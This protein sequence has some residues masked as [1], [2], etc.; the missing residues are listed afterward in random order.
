MASASNS[1]TPPDRH[2]QYSSLEDAL[3]LVNAHRRAWSPAAD[4]GPVALATPL[5]PGGTSNRSFLVHAGSATWV[6]R[7]DGIDPERNGIDRDTEFRLQA[8]AADAGLAPRPRFCDAAAGVLLVDYLAP[9]SGPAG[10]N[11]A[12]VARLLRAVHQLAVAAPR[13]YLEDRVAHYEA[14]VRTT[15]GKAVG[16]RLASLSPALRGACRRLDGDSEPAV[17]CHNDLT[18]ANR[19]SHRG[20]LY[21]L[22]WEYAA[23]GSRW[24]DLAVAAAGR[25]EARALLDAYLQRPATAPELAMFARARLVASYVELLWLACN[26]D[27]AM[28]R[29]SV[30]LRA[31]QARLDDTTGVDRPRAC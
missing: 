8:A 19:L 17:V 10:D 6:L 14:L 12:E 16:N 15:C 31:L 30:G 2:R 11:T 29:L 21:A 26:T 5:L 28:R 22:D 7:L 20:T 25:V 27:G 4:P 24:F 9:D 18:P 13:L 3:A 1:D 23:C